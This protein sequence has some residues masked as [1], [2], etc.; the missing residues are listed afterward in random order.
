MN[1]PATIKDARPTF[2]IEGSEEVELGRG[3]IA[4]SIIE[5]AGGPSRCEATF[6]NW[7]T[8]DQTKDFLYFDRR[9]L[10]F[11]KGM[12]VRYGTDTVFDG[13]I[14]ALEGHFPEGSAPEIIVL[15]DDRLQDLRMTRRSRVFED[16]SDA[17]VFQR[18]AQD[19]GLQPDVQLQGPTHKV[20]A[21]VN[22]SDL[23]FL[24]GRA[25]AIDAELHVDGRTLRAKSRARA[26]S[27]PVELSYG[28]ALRSFKVTADLAHQRTAVKATGWDP[29]DKRALSYEATDSAIQAELGN[30]ESGAS[31][32]RA[33]LSE[34]K[35]V[36]AHGVTWSDGE[37]QARAEAHF[38]HGARRFVVGEGVAA[39]DAQ[40]RAGARVK[41]DGLGALFNGTYHLAEV[42]WLFDEGGL[43]VEFRAERAGIG[44]P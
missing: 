38:R 6:G 22:Q 40:L 18:V 26:S 31:V 30:D 37:T 39:P 8:K 41:L 15:A 13:R 20:L 17:A 1:A 27:S 33:K 19:H 24:Q 5:E 42:R 4:L 35:E 29:E 10:D 36:V 34:R 14:M 43:R 9:T 2:L 23:A 28:A 25:R 21:Q 12:Q 44:R 3:L 32:L 16:M 11:G 7:G